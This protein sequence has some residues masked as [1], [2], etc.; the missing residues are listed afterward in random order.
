MDGF[1]AGARPGGGQ[2]VRL[3]GFLRADAAFPIQRGS[4]SAHPVPPFAKVLSGKRI[5]ER[6]WTK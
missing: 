6:P 1:E 4:F 3:N 2:R 5:L